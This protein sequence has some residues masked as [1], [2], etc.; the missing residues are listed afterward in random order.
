MSK[1]LSERGRA[2]DERSLH[3]AWET[4]LSFYFETLISLSRMD[5]MGVVYA[6]LI[7]LICDF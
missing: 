3:M 6:R 4:I 5:L 1:I 7:S 2:G